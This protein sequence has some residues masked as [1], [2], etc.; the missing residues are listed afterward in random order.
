MLA[1]PDSLAAYF[2]RAHPSPVK[3][4]RPFVLPAREFVKVD[5]HTINKGKMYVCLSMIAAAIAP[6]P[7]ATYIGMLGGLYWLYKL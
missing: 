1:R 7:Y 3:M 4:T 5:K 6:T 2:E